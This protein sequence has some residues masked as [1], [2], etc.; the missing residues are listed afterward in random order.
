VHVTRGSLIERDRILEL[1]L[2]PHPSSVGRA[3]TFV[4]EAL[5][6]WAVPEETEQLARLAI[7]EL[8]TNAIVHART[9]VVVRVRPEA[10]AVWVGVTDQDDTLP[11]LVHTAP[12][13]DGS[14]GLAIVEAVARRWGVDQQFSRPGKTVWF[15]VGLDP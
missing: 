2:S 9:H 15:T 6:R 5:E 14:R 3:R 4:S 12:D 8:V 1:D 13:R 7:S 10:D 11:V